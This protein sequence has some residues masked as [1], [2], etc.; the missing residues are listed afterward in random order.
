MSGMI[1]LLVRTRMRQKSTFFGLLLLVPPLAA[2]KRIAC[3]DGEHIEINVREISIRYDASS[4]SG[5]LGSLSALS[6]RMEVAPKR[7]QEATSA[8]QQWDEL[9]KGLAAGY[10]S[11]AVTRQ[12]YAEGVTRIYPRLK[13]DGDGLDE[14]RKAL[15]AG[16]KI[17]QQRLQRVL[18]SF[19]ANL[20]QF[21]QVSGKE[22]I[23]ERIEALSAQVASGNRTV[24]EKIDEVNGKLDRLRT[25]SQQTPL[26]TPQQVGQQLSDLRE[27]LP[28]R[29][30]EAEAAYNKGYPLLNQYRF[31]EAIP[32][33]Q[34]AFSAV[35]LPDFALS[36]GQA[37]RELPNLPEAERVLRQG[38]A[39]TE[40]GDQKKQ[41]DLANVLSLVLEDQGDLT[42]A[43]E[44][45]QRALRIDEK[46]YGL[47]HPNVGR[48]V[49][50]IGQILQDKGD[51][52]G[53]LEYEQRALRI[54]EKA[55]GPDHPKVGVDVNNI[56]T[57]LQ[58][59]GDLDRAL[60]YEQRALR[61]HEKAYGPDHP[62]VGVDV[63]NVG[64]I[65]KDKGNLNGALENA[66]R[67]LRIDEKAYGPDHPAVGVDVNNIGVILK[68]KGNLNGALE[69]A[70]RALR[71]DEKA[72]GPDHPA[73]GRDTNNIGQILRDK[74]DL[75]G[76]LQNMQRALRIFQNAY[77][78]ENPNTKTVAENLKSIQDALR[79][80][81]NTS[82]R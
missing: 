10:N 66:Q 1:H 78:A 45:A 76:A 67:A 5:T 36:L 81:S 22:I 62:K 29:A 49:N 34:Q 9:L 16:Q 46:A 70:Q 6:G 61:I 39:A 55:Y 60:E 35:A 19:L 30:D 26:P 41:A 24:L 64:T 72:Y 3:P 37:Y 40:Q 2:Q 28:S 47:D 53:A 38:L 23:L 31:A 73:V 7:L 69:N 4:F 79:E 18:D 15:A 58:S 33:L 44:N 13:E 50:N 54:D 65:L 51:L 20:R 59:K 8:T 11:C 82:P 80:S 75:N 57:I 71:I 27:N 21:A 48:D 12:Q 63:N 68:G 77:G 43:M 17:D 42:G 56:G 25:A 74:G 52:N 14:I 32:Y